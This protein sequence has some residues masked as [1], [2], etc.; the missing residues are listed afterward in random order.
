M[1]KKRPRVT[2]AQA[3]KATAARRKKAAAAKRKPISER[4]L[5]DDVTKAVGRVQAQAKKEGAP[6][7]PGEISTL[8]DRLAASARRQNKRRKG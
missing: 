1:A 3:D 8:K 5:M 6:M 7:K 4:K 2:K